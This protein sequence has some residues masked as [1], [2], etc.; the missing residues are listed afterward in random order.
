MVSW[1]ELALIAKW[2]VITA[3][4]PSLPAQPFSDE[5]QSLK[6]DSVERW[7][8]RYAELGT[9]ERVVPWVFVVLYA[10]TGIIAATN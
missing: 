9:V 3:L 1:N 7:R 5:W 8:D 6:K 10:V 2:E 4:E